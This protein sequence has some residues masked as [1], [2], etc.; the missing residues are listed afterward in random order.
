MFK[1]SSLSRQTRLDSLASSTV[2]LLSSTI[3]TLTVIALDLDLETPSGW[4][5]ATDTGGSLL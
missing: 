2:L 1:K 4:L 3:G 5:D